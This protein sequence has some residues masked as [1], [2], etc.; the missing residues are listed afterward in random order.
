M[1]VGV[2]SFERVVGS[3]VV[4]AIVVGSTVVGVSVVGFNV[5]SSVVAKVVLVVVETL[6]PNITKSDIIAKNNN[7]NF[8]ILTPS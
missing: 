1:F 5:V 3:T 8:F 6:Q 7:V 2:E 4:G